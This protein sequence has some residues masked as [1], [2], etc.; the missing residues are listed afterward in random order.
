[1]SRSRVCKVKLLL[2]AIFS[3][4]VTSVFAAPPEW[5]DG[6]LIVKPLAGLSEAR[7]ETGRDATA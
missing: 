2:A 1:M 7:F 6:E 5:V 3:L 4:S